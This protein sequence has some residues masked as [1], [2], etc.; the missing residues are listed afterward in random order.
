LKVFGSLKV[1]NKVN[2]AEPLFMRIDKD[3]TTDVK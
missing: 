3:T 2:V 1:S